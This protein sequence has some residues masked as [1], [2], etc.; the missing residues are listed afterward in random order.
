MMSLRASALLLVF[1]LRSGLAAQS[2]GSP[3]PPIQDNSFLI[4]EAYNQEPGVVQHISTLLRARATWSYSFT[5][6]WPFVGQRHQLSFTIPVE[7]GVGDVAI[8]Y[9]HQLAG[10]KGGPAFAPRLSLLLPTADAAGA[11]VQ[12]NLPL[13]TFVAR[14]VVTHWNAGATLARRD[15]TVYNAGASVIWLFRPSLNF[16]LELGWAGV[17]GEGDVIV[18]PGLRWA[19]NLGALQVVPGIAFPDGR[20]VFLYLSFEHPF[21]TTALR[22]LARAP[23]GWR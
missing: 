19:H 5:Q 7:R 6:E 15:E 9:R 16:M 8:N 18:S 13:S 3:P 12:L 4:E 1:C 23:G 11:A 2:A 21:K 14:G 17:A 22:E 10:L 20:D